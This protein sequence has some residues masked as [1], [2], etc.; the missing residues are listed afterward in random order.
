MLVH[1]ADR[2]TVVQEH[3]R[4]R[5]NFLVGLSKVSTVMSSQSLEVCVGTKG[6]TP[7]CGYC[8]EEGASCGL[9]P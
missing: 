6:G 3:P 7:W 9:T 2:V 1:V 5:K 4:V 8:R